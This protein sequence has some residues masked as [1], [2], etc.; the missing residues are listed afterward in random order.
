MLTFGVGK[1]F[2]TCS[3]VPPGFFL[4]LAISHIAHKF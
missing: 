4:N 1:S 2:E 3:S